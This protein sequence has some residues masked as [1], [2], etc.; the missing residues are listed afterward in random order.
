MAASSTTK[1]PVTQLRSTTEEFLRASK[2]VPN[3]TAR[4]R[5]GVALLRQQHHDHDEHC[6]HEKALRGLLAVPDAGLP[7]RKPFAADGDEA[8]E[9]KQPDEEDANCGRQLRRH[10]RA[11]VSSR[12]K[13]PPCAVQ[14]NEP[15]H[16]FGSDDRP[17][18]ELLQGWIGDRA[19]L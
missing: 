17:V 13:E 5:S 6:A 12:A 1:E 14:A 18:R 16:P 9:V 3:H 10:E 19:R 7:H 15:N 4:A 11:A 8:Y 2:I